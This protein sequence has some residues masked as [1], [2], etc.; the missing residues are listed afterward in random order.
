MPSS[1]EHMSCLSDT[2]ST[3]SYIFDRFGAAVEQAGS[4][5]LTLRR[6]DVGR[7]LEAESAQDT[8]LAGELPVPRL[9]GVADEAEPI[10]VGDQPAIGRGAD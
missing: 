10:G 2:C 6:R 1:P 9:V 4:G 8:G 7:P 3:A 5:R